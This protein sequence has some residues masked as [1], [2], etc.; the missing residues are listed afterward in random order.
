MI[1]FNSWYYSF[2][3][4][5]ADYLTGHWVGRT[6]MKGVLYPMVGILELTSATFSAT[7][8]IP[9]LAVLF[10]G[11]VASSLIGVVYLGLPLSLVRVKVRRLRGLNVQ[12]RLEWAL[13]GLMLGGIAMLGLGEILASMTVLMVASVMVVLS[14]LVL[15]A[16]FTSGR[17]ARRLTT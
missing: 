14:T 12:G 8:A 9:E 11:L 13:A 7:G 15:S 16:I 3:P 5:V 4:R 10:S 2:S 6:I 17:I 1:A